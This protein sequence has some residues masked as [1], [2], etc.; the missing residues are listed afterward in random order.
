MIHAQVCERGVLLRGQQET[1]LARCGLPAELYDRLQAFESRRLLSGEAPVF[2]WNWQKAVVGPYVGIIRIPGLQLELLPKLEQ[3]GDPG[4]LRKRLL[5]WLRW[6]G[7]I[8]IQD[9]PE[10]FQQ[11]ARHPL[12]EVLRLKFAAGLLAELKRGAVGGY[13]GLEENLGVIRGKLLIGRQLSRNLARQ[14]QFACSYEEFSSDTLLNQFLKVTARKML[15][16]GGI[17]E[18]RQCL[19]LMDELSELADPLPVLDRIQITR[20]SERFSE[21]FRLAKLFWKGFSPS[22]STGN[23]EEFS[24]LYQMDELFESF[25]AGFL[26]REVLPS[27]PQYQLFVQAE[28]HSK[29][30][31]APSAYRLKPDL[32]LVAPSGQCGVLD[33]KWKMLGDSKP[34]QSDMY[35]MYAY[36]RRYGARQTLLLYPETPGF[37]KH[38]WDGLD[39]AGNPTG[40]MGTRSVDVALDI[41][42]QEGRAALKN[43]LGDLVQECCT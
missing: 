6:S 2:T 17:P 21:S 33:T 12:H 9:R 37:E 28:K 26:M 1:T 20:Q 30:L 34:A 35:Q 7:A 15:S 18:L 8:T 25:I 5:S 19:F 32:L 16:L 14:D 22:L 23:A 36:L 3:V 43:A 13:I 40:K 11:L 24:L 4:E 39:H 42:R 27:L 10:A 29:T 31:T 38:T 41:T